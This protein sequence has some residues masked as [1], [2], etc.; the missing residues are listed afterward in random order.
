MDYSQSFAISAAGMSVERTRVEVAA[1]NLANANTVQTA[2]GVGFQ[3]L[4]VVARTI[5]AASASVMPGGFA[6]QVA[7]GLGQAA[8]AT[9]MN[10]T[11]PE[12]GVEQSGALPRRV[13]EPG[14][15]FADSKGFVTYPGV[16]T[17]TEMVTM[18]SALRSYEANVA[19]MNTAK[20]LAMKALDIGGASS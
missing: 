8:D 7:A 13:Y 3:P 16:D 1:L 14:N 17:A 5:S 19:A 2:D 4:R 20:T 9:L 15:P 12:V 10:P 18:M 11:L 6:D